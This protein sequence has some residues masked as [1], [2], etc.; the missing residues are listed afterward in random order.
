[1]TSAL[2]C[3]IADL[4]STGFVKSWPERFE[5]KRHVARHDPDEAQSS[6]DLKLS[7]NRQL[8]RKTVGVA[9]TSSGSCVGCE[10]VDGQCIHSL[11][12]PHALWI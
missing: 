12:S 8:G 1:M 2:S 9:S 7:G 6:D 3:E 11:A 5:W 4:L 10:E